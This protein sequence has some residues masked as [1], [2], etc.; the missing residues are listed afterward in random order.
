MYGDDKQTGRSTAPQ[1]APRRDD[2]DDAA[3]Q[4]PSLN[5]ALKTQE[6]SLLQ[7]AVPVS[8][9]VFSARKLG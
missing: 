2:D 9:T 7:H 1:H 6:R 3:A 8:V 5:S 4:L